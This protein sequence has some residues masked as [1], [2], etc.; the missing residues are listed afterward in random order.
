MK[1]TL[2]QQQVRVLDSKEVYDVLEY[3]ERN[4]LDKHEARKLTHL[5]GRFATRHEL[6]MNAPQKPKH[7]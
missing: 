4:D 5:F 2:E 7:R 3:C 1:H 6:A